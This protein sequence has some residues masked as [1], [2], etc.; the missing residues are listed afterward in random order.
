MD[1]RLGGSR[2]WC[3]RLTLTDFRSHAEWDVRLDQRPVCLYGPNGAGKTNI[4]EALTTLAPGRGLRSASVADLARANANPDR[5]RLWSVSAA[6]VADGEAITLGAG[7][8][9]QGEAGAKRITRAEGADASAGDLARA[10]RLAWATPAMDRLFSGPG[11]DRRRFFDRLTLARSPSHGRHAAAYERAMRERQKLLEEG[12]DPAWIAALEAQMARHGAAVAHARAELLVVL[13]AAIA[14]RPDGAFPKAGLALD[15]RWAQPAEIDVLEA[16][17][18]GAL[19]AGRKR[20]AA[21]GRALDGPHRTDLLVRHAPKDMPADLSSTGEQKALL[22]GILLA[23][24][25]ALADDPKAGPCL[26]LLD[27]AGA[28]LDPDRRSALFDETLAL[29]GQTW[30]TGAEAG[31]FSAYGERAQHVPIGVT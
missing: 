17:L 15:G 31:L 18:A 22:L 28:H 9:R 2:L 3:A 6:I 29:P 8:D 24:A 14:A 20:D 25:G 11:S 4:L 13:Q 27:E 21:A 10:C 7:A 16:D 26:L 30:L 5:A 19:R 12:G 23:H 1:A